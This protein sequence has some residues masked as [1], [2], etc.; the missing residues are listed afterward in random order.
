MKSPDLA[1]FRVAF[2]K[3]DHCSTCRL[4][5]GVEIT[6]IENG[7]HTYRVECQLVTY[8]KQVTGRRFDYD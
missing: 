4:G 8:C 6:I 5:D 1:H 2:M 7:D 3:I